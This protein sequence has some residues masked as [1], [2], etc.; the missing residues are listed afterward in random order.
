MSKVNLLINSFKPTVFQPG[1]AGYLTTYT[2]E[3][4]SVREES[5]VY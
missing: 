2:E 4:Q 3:F 1:K 5:D